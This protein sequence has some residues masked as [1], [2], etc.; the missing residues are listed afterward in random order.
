M[1]RR[2]LIHSVLV[3][4]AVAA[5][6]CTAAD[7]PTQAGRHAYARQPVDLPLP[8]GVHD[9]APV[10]SPGSGASPED[11]NARES[12]APLV[13]MPAPGHM[14]AGSTMQR[15]ADRGRLVV[16]V[17]QNTYLFGFRDPVS[18]KIVGFDI[19]IAR[20][21]AKAIFGV[22]DDTHIQFVTLASDERIPAIQHGRVDLVA[23]AMTVTCERRR[24]VAFSTVYYEA[25]QKLL[26]SRDSSIDNL[27]DLDGK[28]VC[29]VAGSTS[30]NNIPLQAPSA[31]VVSARYWT[32]CLVMLQQAQVEAIT[33]DDSILS[34]LAAQ[35]PHLQL[36]G[37]DLNP[38]PYGLGMAKSALDFVRFVNGVLD[39]M[40]HDGTWQHIYTKWLP[41][42]APAPP[43]PQ[44]SKP[45]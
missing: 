27:T 7:Q 9:P 40:R 10:L 4:V 35:D 19:D 31:R 21:V 12:L 5:A 44:Y 43:T 22:D 33:S 38:E 16:G 15:I 29:S 39:R 8:V 20:E 3:M 18:G 45:R 11:C 25:H 34:G 13:P 28:R 36:V 1:T 6:A 2:G 32:D 23:K 26:V 41:K 14:P 30:M 42:P 24:Q 17:D 37:N